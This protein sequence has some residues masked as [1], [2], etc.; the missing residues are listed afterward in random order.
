MFHLPGSVLTAKGL[1]FSPTKAALKD[2]L[3]LGSQ[4]F[5]SHRIPFYQMLDLFA[6]VTLN[7]G[8][9]IVSNLI[10]LRYRGA[11]NHWRQ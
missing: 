8:C 3:I 4:K 6:A 5:Q 10:S 1:Q 7:L 11:S 9:L 2:L